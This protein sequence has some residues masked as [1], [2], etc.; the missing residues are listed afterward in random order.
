AGTGRNLEEAREA[1]FVELPKGRIGLVGTYSSFGGAGSIAA[2]PAFGNVSGLPGANVLHLTAYHVVSQAQLDDLR[3]IRDEAYT[4][5]N[6][7]LY[8]VPPIPAN[9]PKDTLNFWGEM[10]K[11]GAVPGGMSYRM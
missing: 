11:A 5:R 4:H 10:F 6:D 8:P 2:T 3:R 7:V 9:E 1:H